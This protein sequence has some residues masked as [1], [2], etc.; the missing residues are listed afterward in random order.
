MKINSRYQTKN[1][2]FGNYSDIKTYT[3]D[4]ELVN[5]FTLR[6]GEKETITIISDNTLASAIS[7][8]LDLLF[9]LQKPLPIIPINTCMASLQ[10]HYEFGIKLQEIVHSTNKRVAILAS[11]DLSHKLTP[12]APAGYNQEAVAFDEEIINML[13]RQE[14]QKILELHEET[15]QDVGECGLRPIAVLLGCLAA[16]SYSFERFSYEYPFGIGHL[17]AELR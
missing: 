15:L 11:A 9:Q 12:D 6:A 3:P 8:P 4:V 7:I 17:V 13:Q 16:S 5:A 10:Q 14:T 2:S 1:A